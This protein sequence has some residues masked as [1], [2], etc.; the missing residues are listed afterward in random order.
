NY[1]TYTHNAGFLDVRKAAAEYVHKKYNL[2]YAPES[3][4]IVTVGASQAIDITLRTLL[5]PGDEVILPGPVYPGYEPVIDMCQAHA[6]LV[7]T[8]DNGFKLTADL[9]SEA[10]TERTKVLILPYPSNP[11]GVSLS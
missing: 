4:V 7:D 11:T 8:R 10:L 1:T 2:S 5:S 6:Q 3:E 9:I